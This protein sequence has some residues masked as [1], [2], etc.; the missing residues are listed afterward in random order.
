VCL[1]ALGAIPAVL[2]AVDL[3]GLRD[4]ARANADQ[5][6][7]AQPTWVE[8][9]WYHLGLDRLHAGRVVGLVPAGSKVNLAAVGYGIG[10]VTRTDLG[11]GFDLALSLASRPTP[12][13]LETAF[14]SGPANRE[15]LGGIE[16]TKTYVCRQDTPFIQIRTT[17]T[18]HGAGALIPWRL[19]SDVA[20]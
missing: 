14:A 3:T 4:R 2:P 17:V 20:V 18:N 6:P 10:S 7:S 9:H 5:Q 15:L 13:G 11:G 8:S 16:Y 1:L 12:D 19:Y